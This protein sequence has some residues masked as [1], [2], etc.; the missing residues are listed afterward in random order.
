[1]ICSMLGTRHFPELKLLKGG[2]L[3]VEDVAEHPYRI[4][5][6]LLQLA[7]SGVLGQQKAVLLG[8]FSHW[9]P[10]PNDRGYGMKAMLERVRA[11]TKVPLIT[12]LPFGHVRTKVTLPVGRRVQLVVDGRNVLVGW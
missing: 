7:Q 11:E 2:I 3:F 12:G 4:E 6:M 10:L 1:M 5:R 8:A 9:K